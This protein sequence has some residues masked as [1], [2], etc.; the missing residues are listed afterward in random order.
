ML[1]LLLDILR[2]RDPITAFANPLA[3][4][5]GPTW[6]SLVRVASLN[7]RRVFDEPAADG[8]AADVPAA[9]VPSADVPAADGPKF[10]AA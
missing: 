8:P 7:C 4:Y 9:D 6:P 10:V 2:P 1:L 5:T 3:R